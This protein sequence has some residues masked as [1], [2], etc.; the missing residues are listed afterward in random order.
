MS[1]K[2]IQQDLGYSEYRI[3][4]DVIYFKPDSAKSEK[5]FAEEIQ[6]SLNQAQKFISPKFFYDKTGSMLFEKICTLPEYYLTRT[7]IKI[8]KKLKN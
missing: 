5:T 4:S 1:T 6:Y 3:D 7:E 8:L 2:T